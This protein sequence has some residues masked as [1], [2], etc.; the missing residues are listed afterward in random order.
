MPLG[1][2]PGAAGIVLGILGLRAAA[3]GFG[4]NRGIAFAHVLELPQKMSY[5][6]DEYARVNT[7]STRTSPALAG[8]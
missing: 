5:D 2:A 3:R 1:L 4:G 7:T 6:A 8:R